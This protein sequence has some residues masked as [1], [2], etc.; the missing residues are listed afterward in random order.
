MEKIK[1]PGDISLQM[2][3]DPVQSGLS[4]PISQ[5]SILVSLFVCLSLFLSLSL[6]PTLSLPS[7]EY[8][9]LSFFFNANHNQLNSFHYA[10]LS[11]Y[12]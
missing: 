7:S 4:F 10:L 1:N 8:I 12:Y 11:C 3:L 2:Q 9:V 6:S 5:F